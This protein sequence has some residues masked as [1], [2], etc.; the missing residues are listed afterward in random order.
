MTN[1]S[2]FCVAD[3]CKPLLAQL[4]QWHVFWPTDWH[5]P[6]CFKWHWDVDGTVE[7]GEHGHSI[8]HQ[9]P[10]TCV[11]VDAVSVKEKG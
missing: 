4:P 7:N 1:H 8:R 10:T 5:H 3:L 9:E 11:S 2:L 6:R